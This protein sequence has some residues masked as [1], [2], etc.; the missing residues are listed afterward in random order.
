MLR[1][2]ASLLFIIP[3]CLWA[4][5]PIEALIE[6]CTQDYQETGVI[7]IPGRLFVI[8]RNVSNEPQKIWG[9]TTKQGPSA[10]SFVI[11]MANGDSY[12]LCKPDNWIGCQYKYPWAIPPGDVFVIEVNIEEAWVGLPFF[13]EGKSTPIRMKAIFESPP[14]Y[15]SNESR[16]W[17]GVIVSKEYLFTGWNPIA[18]N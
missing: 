15:E 9:D 5:Y 11:T 6:P 10:L 7:M 16:V 18:I 17:V 2:I 3:C 14:C 4:Q 8:L 1:A 12:H 13:P